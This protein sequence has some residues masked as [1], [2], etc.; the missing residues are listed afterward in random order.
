MTDR[1]DDGMRAL[2]D[3]P[4]PD[5]WQDIVT[6]AGRSATAD[7]T[8]LGAQTNGNG[9]GHHQAGRRWPFALA[10]AASV[11]VVAGAVVLVTREDSEVT[12]GGPVTSATEGTGSTTATEPPS[13]DDTAP[14]TT[15][16]TTSILPGRPPNEVVDLDNY[17]VSA[18]RGLPFAASAPPEGIGGTMEPAD[19]QDPR[20]PEL[21]HGNITGVFP[22]ATSTRAVFFV[23]GWPGLQ[24]DAG[25]YIEGP[26]PGVQSWIAPYDDGW[27]AEIAAP[28]SAETYCPY[29]VIGL[30]LG[31]AEMR[32]LLAGLTLE[33]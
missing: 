27:L 33:G 13:T 8:E 2:R 26:F 15:T 14:G 10:V 12:T 11:A 3:E 18:C 6:R 5:Q 9:S 1:Y 16:T 28:A 23:V 32:Q 21:V 24:D 31:E 22:G 20:V 7:A 30:G 4:V 29:T 17:P 19:P 25:I